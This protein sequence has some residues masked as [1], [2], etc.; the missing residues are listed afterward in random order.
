MLVCRFAGKCALQAMGNQFA[1]LILM[2]MTVRLPIQLKVASD[3]CDL[4]R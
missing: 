3:C 2:D 4:D 1:V